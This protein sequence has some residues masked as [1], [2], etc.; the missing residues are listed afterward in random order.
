MPPRACQKPVF[1]TWEEFYFTTNKCPHLAGFLPVYVTSLQ[2]WEDPDGD[3]VQHE[4]WGNWFLKYLEHRTASRNYSWEKGKRWGLGLEKTSRKK[5]TA[6]AFGGGR[7]QKQRHN[8]ITFR[9][10]GEQRNVLLQGTGKGTMG[11][12]L[13]CYGSAETKFTPSIKGAKCKTLNQTE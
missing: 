3:T 11:W 6:V 9:R 2:Y 12:F 7:W 10:A 4:V 5:L 13:E 8:R 1:S